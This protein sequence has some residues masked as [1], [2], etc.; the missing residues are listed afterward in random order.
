MTISGAL[1]DMPRENRESGA[2]PERTHH[3]K[4]RTPQQVTVANISTMG[5]RGTRFRARGKSG[6]LP[7]I[8]PLMD[9]GKVRGRFIPVFRLW[10]FL[11]PKSRT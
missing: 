4:P 11:L 5:R 1:D 10:I 9:D 7:E 3:C 8:H 2:N 6:D